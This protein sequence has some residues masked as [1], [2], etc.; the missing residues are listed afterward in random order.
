MLV[1][2]IYKGIKVGWSAK[3]QER[4]FEDN[5]NIL[6]LSCSGYLVYIH[7]SKLT[8]L[9]TLNGYSIL[10]VIYITINFT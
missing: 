5:G 3:G 9:Y 7:F 1:L 4:T 6:Y 2:L 8:G 10:Y